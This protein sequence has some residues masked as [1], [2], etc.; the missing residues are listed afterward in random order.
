MSK[1]TLAVIVGSFFFG[2]GGVGADAAVVTDITPEGL[3]GVTGTNS[4]DFLGVVTTGGTGTS[5]GINT[6]PSE[7]TVSL[8][9]ALGTLEVNDVIG[10]DIDELS[11]GNGANLWNYEILLPGNAVAGTGLTNISFNAAML[12]SSAAFNNSDLDSVN[13]LK[14]ELFL[15]GSTT[16]TDWVR[17]EAVP[18]G[19]GPVMLADAGGTTVTSARVTVSIENTTAFNTGTET[20]AVT[21]AVL[22]AD[23]ATTAV[24]EPSHL[25][26]LGLMGLVAW[27]RKCRKSI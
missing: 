16:V 23:F 10:Q 13:D 24:P 7:T 14:F 11:G 17:F 25:L 18:Q 6:S 3:T 22:S 21:N 4:G 15:N 20:F 9:E 19:D 5:I 1:F 12:L 2:L 8:Y 27:T 26:A